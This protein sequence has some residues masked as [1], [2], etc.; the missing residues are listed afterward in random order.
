[1]RYAGPPGL[2]DVAALGI[3]MRFGAA[4]IDLERATTLDHGAFPTGMSGN[5][6]LCLQDPQGAR[7]GSLECCANPTTDS[8]LIMVTQALLRLARLQA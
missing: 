4:L 6:K 2:A 7:F 8:A 3:T 5:A 1:M